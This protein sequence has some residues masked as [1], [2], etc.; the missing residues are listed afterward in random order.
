MAADLTAARREAVY[1][2]V[3]KWFHT[4]VQAVLLSSIEK[5]D[6]L[7]AWAAAKGN[8]EAAKKLE[9]DFVRLE[10]RCNAC[11]PPAEAVSTHAKAHSPRC[12]GVNLRVLVPSWAPEINVFAAECFRPA[13][14]DLRNA[15]LRAPASTWTMLQTLHPKLMASL[16]SWE[17]CLRGAPPAAENFVQVPLKRSDQP[18]LRPLLAMAHCMKTDAPPPLSFSSPTL[19]YKFLERC[20]DPSDAVRFAPRCSTL[21]EHACRRECLC[22]KS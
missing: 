18:L 17:D 8:F 7:C 5:L 2:I 9:D 12:S 20:S 21:R 22:L 16:P 11:S 6:A 4:N 15:F 10:G 19:R 14:A 3:I 13:T 1:P